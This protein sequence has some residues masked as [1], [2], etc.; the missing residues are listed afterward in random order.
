MDLRE[1]PDAQATGVRSRVRETPEQTC[2]QTEQRVS[3]R[4]GEVGRGAQGPGSFLGDED[5]MFRN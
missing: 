3:A 4:A 5:E 2:P 1:T